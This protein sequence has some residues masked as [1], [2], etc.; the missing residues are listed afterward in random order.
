MLRQVKRLQSTTTTAAAT[1]A[2]STSSNPPFT[3][4]LIANRGEIACRVMRTCRRLGIRTVA[5]YSDADANALHVRMADEAYPIG[6]APTSKSYLDMAR[7]VEAVKKSGAQA[8]HPGYGFLSENS[9]FVHA[10]NE[11]GVVFIGPAEQSMALMGDKLTSKRIAKESAVNTI[12]GFEGAVRDLDHAL[13]LANQI[14]YPIMLKAVYYFNPAVLSIS[15]SFYLFLTDG[16]LMEVVEKACVSAGTPPSSSLMLIPSNHRSDDDV[17]N[18]YKVA[19]SEAMASFGN[20]EF[21]IEKFIDNPRHIE[22]QIIGDQHGN[23]FY[24][25]E[26]ECSIQ[27][28]NQKVIEEAPSVHLDQATRDAMG[29]QAVALAKRVGYHSA[30]TCFSQHT[31]FRFI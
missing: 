25:P 9:H 2:S 30:G 28:R 15:D 3:K 16:R 26:R 24:L 5:V 1:A 10:L 23:T 29:K 31:F 14:T 20:D 12:P 18:N 13:Q 27:R 11:A 8:V 6:P 17:K 21:L 22:I 7:V 19:K 4:I